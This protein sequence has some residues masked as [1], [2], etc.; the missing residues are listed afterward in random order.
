MIPDKFEVWGYAVET[1]EGGGGI[2]TS[3]GNLSSQEEKEIS[4]FPEKITLASK[5]NSPQQYIKLEDTIREDIQL[6]N[7]TNQN[8][9]DE[10]ASYLGYDMTRIDERK[11]IYVKQD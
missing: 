7:V 6:S 4:R 5:L 1:P 10:I 3:T 11:A 9:F 8:L 2:S